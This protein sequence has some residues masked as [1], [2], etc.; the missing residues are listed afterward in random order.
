VTE[1]SSGEKLDKGPDPLVVSP[2]RV[3]PVPVDEN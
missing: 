1:L 3:L 2:V